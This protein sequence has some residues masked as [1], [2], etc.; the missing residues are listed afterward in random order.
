MLPWP[1]NHCEH[2]DSGFPHE[3]AYILHFSN[4]CQ[5]PSFMNMV[6]MW[7]ARRPGG[8]RRSRGA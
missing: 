6:R 7:A 1:W 5:G 2:W 3:G 8:L 4:F